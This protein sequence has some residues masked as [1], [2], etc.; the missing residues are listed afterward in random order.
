MS[1]TAPHQSFKDAAIAA[2]NKKK[3]YNN[4]PNP[5]QDDAGT[6]PPP[7]RVEPTPSPY[8][9][10]AAKRKAPPSKDYDQSFTA[11]DDARSAPPKKPQSSHVN[12][13]PSQPSSQNS[14]SNPFPDPKPPKAIIAPNAH[15]TK[16]GKAFLHF[17]LN[18]SSIVEYPISSLDIPE[19]FPDDYPPPSFQTDI[20]KHPMNAQS[21][22][23]F[24]AG[25]PAPARDRPTYHYMRFN[26]F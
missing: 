22:S 17:L 25:E 13:T 9:K 24:M 6:P 11:E 2:A 18:H 20:V 19:I 15:S 3:L 14:Q 16:P 26:I 23:I 4:P 7:P 8:K 10:T 5:R 21:L 1:P 12:N